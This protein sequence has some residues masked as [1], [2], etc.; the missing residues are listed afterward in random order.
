[1]EELEIDDKKSG[2]GKETLFRVTYQNQISLIRIADNKAHLIISITSIIISVIVAITG[3]GRGLSESIDI[4]DFR[5]MIPAILILVTCLVSVTYAIRAAM[6]YVRKPE[7]KEGHSLRSSSLLFFAN[8]SEKTM[9]EYMSQ[10]QVLLTSRKAIHENMIVDIYN[11]AKVLTRK[12]RLLRV[13]YLIFMYGII[14]GV[15]VYLL[16]MVF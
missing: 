16:L 10:M 9:E 7:R 15:V 1:M 11:Q 6:P 12:Y 8:I 14:A 5:V 2:R 4:S 13:S 3:L